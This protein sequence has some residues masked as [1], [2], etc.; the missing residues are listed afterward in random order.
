MRALHLPLFR[1]ALL[2]CVALC[3]APTHAQ[4]AP[5]TRAGAQTDTPDG[6]QSETQ[7]LVLGKLSGRGA[8]LIRGTEGLYTWSFGMRMDQTVTQAVLKLRY[9]SSPALLP[10]LSHIRIRVNGEVVATIPLEKEQ[11]GR[12]LKRDI[13][14]DP[15][16]FT[17]Y[18][19]LTV[20]LVGH[21]TEGCEDPQNSALWVSVGGDS[22]LQLQLEGLPLRDELGLLP[23]P[24]LDLRD[25][26]QLELPVLLPAKPALPMIESAGIAASWF[27]AQ[28]AFRGARFPVLLDQLPKR[29]ALVLATNDSSPSVLKLAPVKEA[30]IFVTANPVNTGGKLL[31]VQAPDAAQL[32]M[33]VEALVLGQAILSGPQAVVRSVDPGAPREPYDAPN[34]VPSDRPAALGTLIQD[35]RTLEALG[36]APAPIRVPLRF[37]PDLFLRQTKGIP[38]QL[39][40][41]YSPPL[42]VDNSMLGIS[43]NE[44]T[45]RSQRLLPS[46]ASKQPASLDIMLPSYLVASENTLGFQFAVDFHK[47]GPCRDSGLD[48]VRSAIEPD[49]TL[50]LRGIA[51]YAQMPDLARFGSAAYPFSIHADLARTALVLA[52]QPSVEAIETSLFVLGRIGRITGFPA[53]RLRV[54]SSLDGDAEGRDL[55]FVGDSPALQSLSSA[56]PVTLGTADRRLAPVG[57]ASL[58][59]SNRAALDTAPAATAGDVSISTDGGLAAVAG[60]ELPDG[61]SL[62]GV[63]LLAESPQAWKRLADILEAPEA[64]HGDTVIV[65]PESLQSFDSGR[66]Y[67]VGHLPWLQWLWLLASEHPGLLILLAI[68]ACIVLGF[69]AYW[70]LRR[71]AAKRL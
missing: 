67:H 24:F 1:T 15:A 10:Q 65:R 13:P 9:T 29:H 44:R 12:P 45:V 30:R 36:H 37:P 61:D 62:S 5:Q 52:P 70:Y 11:A 63:A 14:I 33:A 53:V 57:P 58:F 41:R 68:L 3:A 7:T 34:W 6:F 27:G 8:E 69:W 64:L 47:A 60:F 42:E 46:K 56:L 32:H 55:I 49:S 23:A 17:D 21:Y 54:V 66:Y 38:L 59:R 16:Y 71:V 39:I 20:Q 4:P 35:P 22:E 26:Q 19:E 2:L 40:Y 31:V 18:N 50:D 25:F 48:V 51:H 43:L 28:A